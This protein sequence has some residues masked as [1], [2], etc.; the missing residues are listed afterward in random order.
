MAGGS[1]KER[2]QVTYAASRSPL[3]QRIS[4]F[5]ALSRDLAIPYR[6]LAGPVH[7]LSHLVTGWKNE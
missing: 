1:T 7:R 2:V 6:L 4:R 3:P 5:S